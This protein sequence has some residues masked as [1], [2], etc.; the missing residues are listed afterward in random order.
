VGPPRKTHW[1]RGKSRKKGGSGAP[2]KTA[3]GQGQPS[4][5]R[6]GLEVK[7]HGSRGERRKGSRGG[8]GPGCEK[9]GAARN[10]PRVH[11]SRE[12]RSATVDGRIRDLRGRRGD[13]FAKGLTDPRLFLRLVGVVRLAVGLRKIR[14]DQ[15]WN[16]RGGE[17]FRGQGREDRIPHGGGD[18]CPPPLVCSP[19]GSSNS[20]TTS[21]GTGVG[22]EG[23][24][25]EQTRKKSPDADAFEAKR[26][27]ARVLSVTLRFPPPTLRRLQCHRCDGRPN[28]RHCQRHAQYR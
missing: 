27:G 4:T 11:P 22:K 20:S 3:E 25:V 26:E 8:E 12:G 18:S 28:V 21:V 1:F 7:P 6:R 13:S 2:V 14:R 17:T 10:C 19:S 16:R 23:T 9:S 5:G 24:A 15:A